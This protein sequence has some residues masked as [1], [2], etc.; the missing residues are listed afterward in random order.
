MKKIKKGR[1]ER[2]LKAAIILAS[3]AIAIYFGTPS[4][5]RVLGLHPH[6]DIPNFNLAGKRALVV[7]TSQATLGDT[8]QATGVFGSEMTVPYYAFLD[9]GLEVDL[10]SIKG[11]TI[12]VQPGSMS[13]PIATAEDQRFL[14]DR[15]AQKKFT[16]SIPISQ[17]NPADYDVIFVAGG[18]GAAYDLAQ[19]KELSKVISEAS[20]R[21]TILGSV[22]HGALAFV[23]AR[24]VDG[25]PLLE[26]RRVTAVTNVQIKQLGI[27]ITP[28]HPETEL[29][30]AN[31]KFEASTAWR[32]F[33][34]THTVVDGN[35][36][37]GQNQN[38]G[39]ETSHRILELLEAR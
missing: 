21:G 10:A 3:L 14:V 20:A 31:A 38:S 7:T 12:P 17:I 32:D 4:A 23:N 16:D 29:R 11:G 22:C 39:Y 1:K 37:T 24:N 2:I 6:Y 26:G 13:W 8:M 27:E 36:V 25:S 5:L 9:A 35:L 28:L 18:W 30:S 33:F 15:A 34:A 19:S